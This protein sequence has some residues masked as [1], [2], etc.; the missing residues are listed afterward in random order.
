MVFY[1]AWPDKSLSHRIILNIQGGMFHSLTGIIL[2]SEVSAVSAGTY[3]GFKNQKW[4]R[5]LYLLVSNGIVL[6]SKS[7]CQIQSRPQ[8]A[9][10]LFV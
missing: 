6:D 10:E 1:V 5:I 9:I 2:S 7:V 3:S 8:M 4:S